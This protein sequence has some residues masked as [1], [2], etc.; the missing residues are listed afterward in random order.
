MM[1]EAGGPLVLFTPVQPQEGVPHI[2]SA[3]L[4]ITLTGPLK[5]SFSGSRLTNED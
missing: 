4:G 1:S 2:L 5:V 3:H